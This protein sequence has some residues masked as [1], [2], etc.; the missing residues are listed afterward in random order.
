MLAVLLALLAQGCGEGTLGADPDLPEAVGTDCFSLG[1]KVPVAASRAEAD[2]LNEFTVN[3]LHLYFFRMEGHDDASSAYVHDVIVEGSFEF[4]RQLRLDLPDNA[5]H[6]GGLFGPSASECYVYAVANVDEALLTPVTVDGLKAV[7]VGSGFD[8][9]EVQP[10]FAMDGFATLSLDRSTRVVSGTI[11]LERAAAKLT[12]SVDLPASIEV[13]QTVVNPVDGSEQTVTLEYFPRPADMRVWIANG[14]KSSALDTAPVP[15]AD[16]ALYSNEVSIAEGCGSPFTY[17]PLQEKY[18]YV[19]DIP[20]YSYPSKWNAYSPQGNCYMTLEIPWHYADT[21]GSE[22]NV[23]TYYRLNVQPDRNAI[24]RNTF[25]DMRVTIGRLGGTVIQEPVDMEFEWDYHMQWNVQ[26]LVTDIKEVRY[27]L[28]N[29]NDFSSAL[30]AYAFTMD[31]ETSVSVPYNTSH[32]V[33]IESVTLTWRD[34]A[35]NADRR[36]ILTTGSGRNRYSDYDSY[37]AST[38]YAGIEVDASTATLRLRRDMR[39]IRWSGSNPEITSDAAVCAYTFTIKLRHTD[40]VTGDPSSHATVVITQIPAINITTQLTASGTR[41]INNQNRT[42]E[43]EVQTGGSWWNPVYTYYYKGYLTTSD[44][45]P[46]DSK[47]RRYWLGSYHNDDNVQ[48]KRTYVL[49]ISKF[50]ASDDYIIAD[51]RTR[52]VDNLNED[53]TAATAAADWSMEATNMT[54]NATNVLMRNYYPADGAADMARFIAPKLRVASQ[55][56]VT[57]QMYRRGAQRRCASYQ[58][59]GRPAGRW[60]LPTPAE[61]EYICRLS[62]RQYIPYLFGTKGSTANYWCSTGGVDVDN[63]RQT[64]T[65]VTTDDDDRRAVRCV[66][67]EWFWENDTLTA[68]RAFRW[69]DRP[70]T[71]SGNR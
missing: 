36:V 57:Y 67:D 69:G 3:S 68:K 34:Y 32:P 51:P 25:Y 46:R 4:S 14:V 65:V 59:D 71:N 49:T 40:A 22:K 60:R 17:D 42:Y 24:E 16:D 31:N 18:H 64:V 15:P 2:G 12:L 33:E 21:D 62:N 28:L 45:A 52:T 30:D 47:Q 10:M 19:Q 54:D 1:V 53:G 23:V 63:A 50:D 48:N 66:Y 39:H 41:F 58:E 7:T 29:N 27:L 20:F 9:T 8:R 13:E 55:W 43:T 35:A 5:L 26:R 56:G 38:V 70:R 61:I 6:E 37:N 44:N 11:T